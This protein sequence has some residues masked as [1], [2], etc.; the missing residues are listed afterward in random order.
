MLPCF[1][2]NA[3]VISIKIKLFSSMVF[4]AICAC[5]LIEDNGQYHKTAQNEILNI[6]KSRTGDTFKEGA[7]SYSTMCG[8]AA[9]FL[10]DPSTATLNDL[11]QMFDAFS[12][13]DGIIR[14]KTTN[15]F[16]RSYVLPT[17]DLLKDGYAEKYRR[18]ILALKDAGFEKLWREKI[19]PVEQQQISRLE[20]ALADI[21]ID[22][23]LESISK[24][25]CT[26]CSEVT[27]YISLLSYP[28]SFSLGETAFLATINDGDDSDYYKNGF[29]ALLSHE[30]M[31]GF[32]S[33]ELIEIYLDFMKQSRYLRST[34]DFLLKELHSGN[35]EEFVMA[36]EYYILWRAGFMTKEEI[37]LKNYSRYGGCVPLAFYLFEHM[38]REKSEPIA[39]Y[40]QW[41]LQ[42]FKN[43]TFSPE[44]LIPTID[45]LLPPPDNIDRF[46][47]NLFVILQRCSFI[48]R[49]AALYVQNDI[50][51]QIE[52]LTNAAF[53]RNADKS[54]SFA[55]GRKE[56]DQS[57]VRETLTS[58]SLTIER[59]EFSN[60]KDAL[61]F[62]F[63]GRGSNIGVP[64]LEYEGERFEKA[65][66]LNM[67]YHKDQPNRAE[68][69]LICGSV[70]YLIT[71]ACPDGVVDI[72]TEKDQFAT[73]RVYGAEMIAAVKRAES[74]VRLLCK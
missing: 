12:E 5:S 30:L 69:S 11:Y 62:C 6:L 4:D 1:H 28:V 63:P 18:Y 68:F 53:I 26:V 14:S 56:L 27:V 20:N 38:T 72:S 71:S 25:K 48:I 43:G 60:K 52:R 23:M 7:L 15:E 50:K 34:H 70:K 24:L 74:I 65:Y 46:F 54:I 31:H 61:L 49:D 42:R 19:L 58:G 8:I 57:C 21:E 36:A 64:V 73:H 3:E 45:S 29:P 67:A 16:E 33:M 40:N 51:E 44:E 17:L 59:I 41:L 10:P 37:L 9:C 2:S 35:E 55:N 22:S 13:A 39:D 32:A 66:C 47:A